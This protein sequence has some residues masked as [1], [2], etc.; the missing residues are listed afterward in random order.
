MN[1]NNSGYTEFSNELLER[2]VG[3]NFNG[4][5]IR[6][7]MAIVRQTDGFHADDNW[8]SNET[9][10]KMLRA[11]RTAIKKN[12]N[13]LIDSNVLIVTKN[14]TKTTSRK[15]KINENYSQWKNFDV[16]GK[17][18]IVLS[19]KYRMRSRLDNE[20]K[21]EA[22]LEDDILDAQHNSDSQVGNSSD[23]HKDKDCSPLK[24]R[25]SVPL[26][27]NVCYPN[28]E[29]ERNNKKEK[30]VNDF[31]EEIWKLLP[32]KDYKSRV[33]YN[34][35]KMLYDTYGKEVLLKAAEY[36]CKDM[37]KIK[38][39]DEQFI[40]QASNFFNKKAVEYSN[41]VIEEEK[42]RIIPRGECEYY[43]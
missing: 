4:I 8:M 11:S 36:F 39:E 42:N 30:E 38:K 18:D 12:L 37:K 22:N 25:T 32:R 28:K 31:F 43:D 13:I 15:L 23:P 3:T 26:E 10:M 16:A 9:L 5:Q 24:S 21:S 17:K 41:K 6:I 20:I 27:D 33:K 35:K 7:L 29:R 19:K 14:Y 1:K 34:Q 2:I 40:T